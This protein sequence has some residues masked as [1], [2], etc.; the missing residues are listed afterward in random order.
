MKKTW[1]KKLQILFL[2]MFIS[3]LILFNISCGLD[4][5][6]VIDSP[7]RTFNLPKYDT[8]D[9]AL[10]N[11][12]FNTN[13]VN[14]YSYST[15]TFLGTD[16]YYRIYNNYG[17]AETEA[18]ALINISSADDTSAN[19][20]SRLIETYKYK[21]VRLANYSYP[22]LIPETGT[23]QRVF[24]RLTS[25]QDDPE[26]AARITVDGNLINGSNSVP[27]RHEDGL[28][29]DFGRSGKDIKSKIPVN[30]D[31]DV[32]F[33][34]T[35]SEAGKWYVNMFAVAVGRDITYKNSYSNILFLGTVCINDK[36]LDN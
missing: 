27:L 16:V 32:T 15:I 22:V 7:E 34:S 12:E 33:S 3:G 35:T 19:A 13:E 9:F 4:T 26:L 17:T 14:A 2:C 31:D 24:I 36:E 21:P 30:N 25:Y 29:F 5:F 20:A 28:N 23:N 11:F 1:N 8:E 18:N 6:E 10:K